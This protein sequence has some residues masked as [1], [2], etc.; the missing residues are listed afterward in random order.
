MLS[1]FWGYLPYLFK[2][3][4]SKKN[5]IWDTGTPFQGLVGLYR[6]KIIRKYSVRNQCYSDDKTY[7]FSVE[8]SAGIFHIQ[9]TFHFGS[10]SLLLRAIQTFF[11][12]DS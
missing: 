11:D 1:E 6:R 4:I 5:R 7:T 9:S 2:G 10:H 8:V 3:Y 12:I